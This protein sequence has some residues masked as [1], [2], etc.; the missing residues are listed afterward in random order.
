MSET[1]TDQEIAAGLWQS[2]KPGQ[3]L[4][5]LLTTA[6][7]AGVPHATWMG[8]IGTPNPSLILTITSPDSLKVRN[9]RENPAVEWLLSETSR[10]L[11]L[12]LRGTAHIVDDVAEQK[13]CWQEIPGKDQAYFLRYFNTSPGFAIIRTEVESALLVVPEE[14][15]SVAIPL[16]DLA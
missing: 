6:S 7:S 12:Y 10:Q 1:G 3:P 11:L 16:E 13:R 4:L 9:I 15:R 8:T 14:F 5:A 2:L